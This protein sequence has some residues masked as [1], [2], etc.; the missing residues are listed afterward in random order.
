M[1]ERTVS[2]ATQN[3]S[4]QDDVYVDG[5]SGTN[6]TTINVGDTVLWTW[7]GSNDHTVSSTSAEAFDSLAPK[8]SG[9]FSHTFNTA[10]SFA[11]ICGI[12]GT[13]MAGTIVVQA[14]QAPTNTPVP[15]T[16]TPPAATNTPA[17]QATGTIA[18][19]PSPTPVEVAPISAS[20]TPLPSQGLAATPAARRALPATG[21]GDKGDGMSGWTVV[22]TAASLVGLALAGA[23]A[24]RMFRKPA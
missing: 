21:S 4:V 15:P 19:D 17:A 12:H 18:A 22:A 5:T 9:T 8:A 20:V 16:S 11:Y 24:Y 10:G 23:A 1:A 6:T 3:V 2:A 13:A 14:A 7:S